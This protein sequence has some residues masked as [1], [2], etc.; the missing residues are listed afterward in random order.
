MTDLISTALR[1]YEFTLFQ[2]RL[3]DISAAHRAGY[4][5]LS[6]LRRIDDFSMSLLDVDFTP[7]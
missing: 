3:N 7:N 1:Q 5:N 2:H 4:F 6:L